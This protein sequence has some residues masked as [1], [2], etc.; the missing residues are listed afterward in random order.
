MTIQYRT[1]HPG[2]VD[3]ISLYAQ[4]KL[5]GIVLIGADADSYKV[6]GIFNPVTCDMKVR[7]CR[8]NNI[9]AR[10]LPL[11]APYGEY[12]ELDS[13]VN[14][15]A[16]HTHVETGRLEA[17]GPFSCIEEA[18]DY[19]PEHSSPC[20]TLVQVFAVQCNQGEIAA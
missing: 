7:L 2:P 10:T 5:R 20:D 12:E 16:L 17:H 3:R 9:P 6:P 4:M 1:A 15:V 8:A 19:F 11:L 13:D 14:L 18:Y